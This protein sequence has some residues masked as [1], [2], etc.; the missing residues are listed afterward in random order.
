[1]PLCRAATPEDET[2]WRSLWTRYLAFYAVD[3]DPDITTATW[4]RA[5]DPGSP[6]GIRLAVPNDQPMGFVTWH[7][8]LS[9]WSAGPDCYLEDLFVASEMRAKGLGRALIEDVRAC[10]IAAG[11]ARLYWH[12]D[13]A[14]SRARAL[15]DTLTLSD[16]HLRYRLRL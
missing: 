8:H 2:A 13:Q 9:T 12:T 4:A 16:G 5:M 11:C 1:M 7:T 14:N 6:L 10:A 15:Y 3:L